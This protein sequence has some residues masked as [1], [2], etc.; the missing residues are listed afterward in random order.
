MFKP[1]PALMAAAALTVAAALVVP[2]VS[3]AADLTPSPYPT[4]T[5]TLRRP[6]VRTTSSGGSTSRRGSSAATKTRASTTLSVATNACRS[7]AIEG[8]RP[9]YEAA[10]RQRPASE[11]HRRRGRRQPGRQGG[12]ISAGEQWTAAPRPLARARRFSCLAASDGPDAVRIE[13]ADGLF[14]AVGQ[15][16]APAARL[17]AG[18]AGDEIPPHDR[19]AMQPDEQLGVQTFLQRRHRMVDEPAPA[20]DVEPHVIALR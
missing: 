13:A 17:V 2:T 5:S 16:R 14:G 11:R 9:A 4:P 1:N 10:T 3:Q 7:G 20:A 6:P 8:A 15:A 19:G 18:E 12:K